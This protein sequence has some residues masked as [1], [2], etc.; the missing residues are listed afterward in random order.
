[1]PASFFSRIAVTSPIP[2]LERH[3]MPHPKNSPSLVGAE[4]SLE[5]SGLIKNIHASI[6][7]IREGISSKPAEIISI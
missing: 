7:F 4:A 3:G 5:K 6:W 2:S 1:M